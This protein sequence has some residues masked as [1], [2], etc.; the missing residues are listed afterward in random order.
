LKAQLLLIVDK[1][2]EEGDYISL[3]MLIPNRERFL[4]DTEIKDN[5][6]DY[7]DTLGEIMN[8]VAL[9]THAIPKL[10]VIINP[11]VWEFIDGKEEEINRFVGQLVREL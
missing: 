5:L 9:W 1:N 11:S 10:D 7:K 3:R 6:E 4:Y 8:E 2:S